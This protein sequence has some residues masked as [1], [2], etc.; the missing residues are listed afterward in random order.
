MANTLTE[1]GQHEDS[2]VAH[3]ELVGVA[4]VVSGGELVILAATESRY[5]ESS[6]HDIHWAGN[7]AAIL[8]C[9]VTS[10]EEA[11]MVAALAFSASSYVGSEVATL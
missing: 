8:T 11:A 7:V 6:R 3:S 9:G 4:E 2:V 5:A 1:E 10:T